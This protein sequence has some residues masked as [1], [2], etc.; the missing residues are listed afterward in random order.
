MNEQVYILLLNL[1]GVPINREAR[2]STT[3]VPHT[4]GGNGEGVCEVGVLKEGLGPLNPKARQ[5]QGLECL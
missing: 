4:Q 1:I 3:R 5:G 2:Y